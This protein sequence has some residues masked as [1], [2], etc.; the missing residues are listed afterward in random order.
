MQEMWVWSLGWEDPLEEKMA[1]HSHSPLENAMTEE[2]GGL[3]PP[4]PQSHTWP[5]DWASMHTCSQGQRWKTTARRDHGWSETTRKISFCIVLISELC[6]HIAYSTYF[7]LSTQAFVVVIQPLRG[8]QLCD[9][10]DCSTPGFPVLHYLRYHLE[11]AQVYYQ[12]IL[13]VEF[14]IKMKTMWSGALF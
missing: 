8:V 12:L 10:M 7:Q 4:G 1:T 3:Q 9:L 14:S 6:K 5:S 2:P 11:S 13:H